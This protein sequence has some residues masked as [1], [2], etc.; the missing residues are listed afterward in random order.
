[1]GMKDVHRRKER[2]PEDYKSRKDERR[3]MAKQK[4]KKEI[5]KNTENS[6]R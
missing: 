5:S 2:D 3:H 6:R 1:M 4:H